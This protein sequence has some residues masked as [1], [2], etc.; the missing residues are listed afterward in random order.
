MTVR[1]WI[2]GV[3]ALA[4]IGIGAAVYLLRP[5]TGP[6]R[7]LTLVGD[8]GRGNYLIRLGG[9]VACHTDTKTG[10]AFLSGGA[11]LTTEFGTFVPSQYYI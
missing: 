6:T 3:A 10:R 8:V 5:V 7:D 1:P 2:W 11:G 9:C 4:V